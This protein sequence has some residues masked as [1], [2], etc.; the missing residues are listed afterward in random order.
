MNVIQ[1]KAVV[2]FWMT[3]KYHYEYFS[4]TLDLLAGV[5]VICLTQK[6]IDLSVFAYWCILRFQNTLIF[7][8]NNVTAYI[9]Y[10]NSELFWNWSRIVGVVIAGTVG[11]IVI[12][13]IV[14]ACIYCKNKK[15]L[16]GR[17]RHTVS[18]RS[19]NRISPFSYPLPSYEEIQAGI[20]C[21]LKLKK[22]LA[23]IRTS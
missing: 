22:G 4:C 19:Q 1:C 6:N 7:F 20:H 10:L 21:C 23:P 8:P 5:R 12:G 16:A 15:S 3:H 13:V 11:L 14:L 2:C 17:L 9:F 18:M